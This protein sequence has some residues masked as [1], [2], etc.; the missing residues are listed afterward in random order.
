MKAEYTYNAQVTRIID[1]DTFLVRVDAGFRIWAEMP[2]RLAHV[3][4]PE[5][6]T[7][8]GKAATAFVT[9]IFGTLPA[10][11]VVHTVAPVENYGRYLAEVFIGD[12]DLGAMMLAQGFAVPYPAA[13]S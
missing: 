12:T 2:L 11:V 4:A 13:K 6:F 7:E 3:N 10:N 8:E 9:S 5:R 1:A